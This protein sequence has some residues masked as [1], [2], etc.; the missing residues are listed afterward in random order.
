MQKIHFKSRVYRTY[1]CGFSGQIDS[2]NLF[3][4][5]IKPNEEQ[6]ALAQQVVVPAKL[7]LGAER[8]AAFQLD[9]KI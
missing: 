3:L 4:R 9:R 1:K 7:L 8:S 2:E 5:L 6:E